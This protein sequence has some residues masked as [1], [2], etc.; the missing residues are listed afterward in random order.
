MSEEQQKD[1]G[2][3]RSRKRMSVF[4]LSEGSAVG[5]D[6]MPFVGLDEGVRK[7]LA[8]LAEFGLPRE[9]VDPTT[10]LFALPGEN[11]L[12]LC[13][14]WFKSGFVLPKHSHSAD[15]VYYIL[16]GS[17][18]LGTQTLCKGDGFFVPADHAY[19]FVVGPEG[20]EVLEFRNA[21]TFNVHFK[22]NDEA[23][24]DKMVAAYRAGAETW[25]TEKPP[26]SAGRDEI[27]TKA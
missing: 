26:F 14:A 8:R 20:A 21:A 7:G 6:M 16:G 10:C 4:R 25:T 22:G 23:H 2:K 19:S 18:Q 1:A 9:T 5:H 15:C 12:S 24:F 3:V 27:S 17:L 13:H 11:G